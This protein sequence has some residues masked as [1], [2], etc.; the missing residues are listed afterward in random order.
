MSNFEGPR[1]NKEKIAFIVKKNTK[2][3]VF[4]NFKGENLTFG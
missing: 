4:L 1:E 3:K 2:F